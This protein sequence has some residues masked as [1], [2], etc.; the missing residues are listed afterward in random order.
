MTSIAVIIVNY[1]TC[2]LAIAA[3]ESVRLRAVGGQ[4]ISIHVVDNA[5]PGDDAARLQA[6]HH[7]KGWGAQVTLHLEPEN[8]GFGRANNLVIGQLTQQDGPPDAVFLLN[9]DAVLDNDAIDILA[10][11]LLAHPEAGFLGA[12]VLTPDGDREASAYRFPSGLGEFAQAINFGPISRALARWSVNL[13]ND[14]P[15]GPVDWVSGAGM[16][17]RMQALRDLGGFDPAFFLY[18]EEVELMWR[19]ARQGWGSRYVP[20]ARIVH[21]A[22]AATDLNNTNYLSR[23]PAYLHRSWRHYFVKTHGRVGAAVVAGGRVTGAALNVVISRARGRR[24]YT[25]PYFFQDFWRYALK[26]ILFGAPID[27]VSHAP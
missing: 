1:A 8:H 18:Y 25:P 13:P 7:A 27:E 2:D 23:K 11:A 15:E 10:R 6:A 12:S 22:G 24:G 17:I 19:G 14:L 26:P 4:D 16:M 20:E 5:S 9:P 3:V 21:N